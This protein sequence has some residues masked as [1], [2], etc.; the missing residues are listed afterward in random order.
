M[1]GP[2]SATYYLCWSITFCIELYALDLIIGMPYPAVVS[3][4]SLLSLSLEVELYRIGG[5]DKFVRS[6]LELFIDSNFG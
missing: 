2:A 3:F 5:C 4:I 1:P 6:L